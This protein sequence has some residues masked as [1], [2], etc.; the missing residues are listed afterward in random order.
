MERDIAIAVNCDVN[1]PWEGPSNEECVKCLKKAGFK[2]VFLSWV[3]DGWGKNQEDMISLLRKNNIEIIFAHIGYKGNHYID[4]IWEKG[5]AGDDFVKCIIEDIKQLTKHNIKI[6]VIHTSS[7]PIPNL[8][9]LGIKRWKKIVKAAEEYGFVLA[10]ENLKDKSV[11][12]YIFE[13]IK[14]PNLKICYDIGHDLCNFNG[15]FNLEDYHDMVVATHIHDNDGTQDLHFLPFHGVLKWKEMLK[16]L[17]NSGFTG[18]LTSESFC[19]F[20]YNI[21][22]AKKFYKKAYE[23]MTKVDEIYRNL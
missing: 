20:A 17:K 4:Q 9:E 13:N 21:V 5:K 14:S 3:F 2:K 22:D 12:N 8:C 15:E 10:T 7:A 23:A 6:G 18:T 1:R 19:R 11:L 16:K